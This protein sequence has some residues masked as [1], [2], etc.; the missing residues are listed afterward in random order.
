MRK[1]VPLN[2]DWR[3]SPGFKTGYVQPDFDDS[4]FQSVML[5][6]AN[7]ELPYDN[8]NEEDYQF[9]S[10]YRRKLTLFGEDRKKRVLLCFEGV[11]AYAEVYFNGQFVCSHK[12][13]YT[14]F[15]CDVTKYALFG[16]ENLLVVKTDSTERDD[17]PPF[18]FVIDYLTY[19]GIY[20]EVR[21]ELTDEIYIEDVFV[22]TG[23]VLSDTKLID[24]EISVANP[25]GKTGEL[26]VE[27]SVETI[28]LPIT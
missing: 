1:L 8:F 7:H 10:C 4:D 17:I 24:V 2:F 5:P 14:P 18:G 27:C 12:G 19:G 16:G 21:L 26:P 25:S 28:G 9:V 22:R 11:M 23:N 6:H 15:R 3:L 13:G 20:R